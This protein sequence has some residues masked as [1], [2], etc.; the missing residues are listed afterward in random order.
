MET[1]RKTNIAFILKEAGSQKYK[2]YLSVFFSV[3]SGL[4]KILPYILLQVIIVELLSASPDKEKIQ[5]YIFI[6]FGTVGINILFLALGLAFSHIAAFSI[7]FKIRENAID[8]MG[9]LGLGFFQERS[10]GQIKKALDEDIEKLELFIAHQIPDL[11]ESIITPLVVIIYLMQINFWLSLILFIPFLL[12]LLLQA[13]IFKGYEETMTNYNQVLKIMH[14]TIVEYIHGMRVFK[15]FNL[16]A[17][18]FKKYTR[19]VDEY[20]KYW[21]KICDDT[22]KS[23]TIGL[24]IIDTSGLLLTIPVGGLLYLSGKLDFSGFV[25]FLLLSTV[26]L[27]AFLKILSMSGNLARLLTGADNIREM[28]EVPAL[29]NGDEYLEDILGEV[30]FQKVTFAYDEKNV[31]ENLSFTLKPNTV[32][33]LVGP[34][35]SGKTTVGML[36]GRF[37]DISQGSITIDGKELQALALDSLMEKTAFVFQDVFMLNDTILNN[38]R[39][40]M[41]KTEEEVFVAC[42]KA[43]IHDFILTLPN[44]YGT[45]IG[46]KSGIKLSGGEKQRIAIARALLKDAQIVILDEVTAYSDIENEKNIQLALRNLLLNRTGLIIAH[47]LYTIQ[48]VD[49]ILVLD[50]GQLVEQG[51]HRELLAKEGLYQRLWQ[52]GGKGA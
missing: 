10:S 1:K 24:T 22:I 45:V 19:T 37:W 20:L 29:T 4:C 41:D 51:T 2:M 42:Q 30:A 11:A 23:Y 36:L 46:E 35:G 31:L 52:K 33:A 8:H 6:C 7:L 49:Q 25:M 43:Q 32:T 13:W 16:S 18:N 44:D 34:S 3:V 48:N 39:L 14:G 9:K 40:G 15:A 12:S 38:I 47:R 50:E 26:F 27:T 21:I 17:T 5:L 28:M